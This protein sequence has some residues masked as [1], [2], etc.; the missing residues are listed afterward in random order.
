[1]VQKSTLFLRNITAIDYAWL[2]PV[3]GKPKG[4]SLQLS[5]MVSG[6]IDPHEAVV[7]DFSKIKKKIK[8][9][10]DDN[11]HGFDHKLWVPDNYNTDHPQIEV[12][13]EAGEIE[14]STA[15]FSTVCPTNAVRFVNLDNITGSIQHHLETELRVAYPN[16]G[17]KVKVEL[18]EEMWIPESMRKCAMP[19]RYVHGL[20]NSSSWG[21]Q[22]I[23]H[24][25][26]SWLAVC[27]KDGKGLFI[28]TKFYIKLR[29]DLEDVY[30]VWDENILT[31]S[32]TGIH[33]GYK[34][35]RGYFECAY[36]ADANIRIIDKDTTVEN[37]AQWFVTNYR[38]DL[39]T[40]ELK[41]AGAHSVYV[42][43]GLTKGS[44][45]EI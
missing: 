22:N 29:R 7:V 43:E 2:D 18:S 37:L 8:A 11:E 39:I 28:P 34:C 26:L 17:I 14:I 13:E 19:F 23:N 6:R 41:E 25:H 36:K 10:I 3:S 24:G 30:F 45:Q 12:Y 38:D 16:V 21:C 32:K 44:Y 15:N 27:N 5:A 42:S 35:K 40:G 20:K 4:G 31:F 33:I 9:I 1:M